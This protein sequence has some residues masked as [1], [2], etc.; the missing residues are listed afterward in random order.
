MNRNGINYLNVP[1]FVEPINDPPFIHVPEFIILKNSKEDGSL[2]FDREQDKFEF[3]IGDPD[4]LYVP[5]MFSIFNFTIGS[6]LKCLSQMKSS[7]CKHRI[8]QQYI[9][10]SN[11]GNK[12]VLII[13]RFVARLYVGLSCV[14][15]QSVQLKIQIQVLL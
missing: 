4:L 13:K 1:V 12:D 10:V 9:L 11:L 2:I 14:C 15:S 3:F 5:G 8:L 6:A 7:Y